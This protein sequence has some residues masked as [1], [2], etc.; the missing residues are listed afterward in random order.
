MTRS[1]EILRELGTQSDS[2]EKVIGQLRGNQLE[3]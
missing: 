1:E 2:L 3:A